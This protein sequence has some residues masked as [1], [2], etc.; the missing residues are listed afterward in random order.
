MR[1]AVG[2]GRPEPIETKHTMAALRQMK[3]R[4]AAHGPEADENNPHCARR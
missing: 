4:C 2:V 1:G 3:G